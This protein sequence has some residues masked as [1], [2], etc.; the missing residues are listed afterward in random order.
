LLTSTGAPFAVT[1]NTIAWI[2]QYR[3]TGSTVKLETS[4]ARK[5]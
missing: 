2:T 5:R 1:S 4:I 3:H